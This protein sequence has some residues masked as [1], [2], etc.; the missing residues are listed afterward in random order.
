MLNHKNRD[1]GEAKRPKRPIPPNKN[2][3]LRV[4]NNTDTQV[5]NVG[6]H[7]KGAATSTLVGWVGALTR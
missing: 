4:G 2:T 5:P 1:G 3:L 6:G 7:S